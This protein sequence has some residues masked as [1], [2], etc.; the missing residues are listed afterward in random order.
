MNNGNIC[1]S[2]GEVGVDYY[3]CHSCC[4]PSFDE[5]MCE[6]HHSQAKAAQLAVEWE[7]F[8]CSQCNLGYS[9]L[10][11]TEGDH[12]FCECK[13]CYE[14]EMCCKECCA[15]LKAEEGEELTK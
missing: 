8:I 9:E 2:C 12:P 15:R 3:C 1:H 10:V 5:W 7:G 6:D 4:T 14:T 13:E 11:V